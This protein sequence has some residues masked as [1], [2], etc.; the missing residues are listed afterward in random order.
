MNNL[1]LT[2]EQLALVKEALVV[3]NDFDQGTIQQLHEVPERN[4]LIVAV[5]D[6]TRIIELCDAVVSYS[7]PSLQSIVMNNGYETYDDGRIA[8]FSNLT[9]P[10]FQVIIGS[11]PCV[12]APDRMYVPMDALQMMYPHTIK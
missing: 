9:E 12:G 8:V 7:E 6:R 5:D 3:M 11:F 4:Q 2:N 10:E 1:V